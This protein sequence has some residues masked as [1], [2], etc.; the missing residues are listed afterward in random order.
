M[1]TKISVL[2]FSVFTSMA[3]HAQ[4]PTAALQACASCHGEAGVAGKARTP[5]LNGQLAAFL[6]ES[7]KAFAGG[8]R[9]TAIAEHKTFPAAEIETMA[10]YYADQ[11]APLRPRQATD[12]A[13]VQKG[14]EIYG[15]RCADCHVDSGRESD[16]DAPLVAAQDKDFLVAQTL[17]FKQGARKFPFMMDDSYRG[18]SDADLAAVAEYF[19]AQ[20][21]VAPPSDKKRRRR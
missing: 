19:A 13:T 2:L 11:K 16:K 20:E 17:L 21:Q 1:N 9:P 6:A 8:R 5:H 4:M 12:P 15:N 18:L 3:C 14:A 10:A 7:M